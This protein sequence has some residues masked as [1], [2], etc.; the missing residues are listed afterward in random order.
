M[1]PT[2]VFTFLPFSCFAHS[3]HNRST[4]CKFSF[5]VRMLLESALKFTRVFCIVNMIGNN[6]LRAQR[7]AGKYPKY[8]HVSGT[9]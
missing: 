2:E 5:Q 1:N 6:R 4:K 8:F 7:A 3:F 9:N